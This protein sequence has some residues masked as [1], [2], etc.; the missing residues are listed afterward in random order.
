L[1]SWVGLSNPTITS[2]AMMSSQAQRE[3]VANGESIACW[4]HVHRAKPRTGTGI[5]P[6]TCA[7]TAFAEPPL[8]PRSQVR[9]KDLRPDRQGMFAP[10]PI[11]ASLPRISGFPPISEHEAMAEPVV[12]RGPRRVRD[13]QPGREGPMRKIMTAIAAAALTLSIAA[14]E[15]PGE[16]AVGGAAIGGLA[17]A[18]IGGAATGRAGGALAGGAIGAAGGAIVG[19]ATAPRSRCPYG[20]FRDRWGNLRCR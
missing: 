4:R 12:V 19:S 17:G 14:C 5:V 11:R 20:T 10:D 2:S 9:P 15:T 1:A 6:R 8:S 13:Q 3:A 7:K 16:R 18:A